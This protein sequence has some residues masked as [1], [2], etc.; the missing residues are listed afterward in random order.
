MMKKIFLILSLFFSIYM[1]SQV[2]SQNQIKLKQVNSI[3]DSYLKKKII[4][5]NPKP[6]EYKTARKFMYY[7]FDGDGDEDLYAF[8][9][10]EGFGGGNNWQHYIAIFEIENNLVKAVDDMVLYG[11]SLKEYNNGEFLK[12]SNGYVYF[13]LYGYDWEKQEKFIKTIG[14]TFYQKKIVTDKKY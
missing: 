13:R 3:L 6:Q 4:N 12:F 7:D 11:D 9:T 2:G 10:L 14:F 8:F 1:Y 5:E